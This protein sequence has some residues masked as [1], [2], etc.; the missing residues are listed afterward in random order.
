MPSE[1][2]S[3]QVNSVISIMRWVTG[4]WDI[5]NPEKIRPISGMEI[6]MRGKAR[7]KRK[8]INPSIKIGQYYSNRIDR[9]FVLKNQQNFNDFYKRL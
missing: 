6:P 9:S 2:M 3:M 8:N 1:Q 7:N 4:M 5:P